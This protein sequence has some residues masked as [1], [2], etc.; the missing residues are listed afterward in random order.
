MGLNTQY[1]K[2]LHSQFG[3]L[4]TWLPTASLKLGDI[5]TI[6]DGVFERTGNLKDLGIEFTAETYP[7]A[8]DLEYASADAVSQEIK[9]GGNVPGTAGSGG[10]VEATVGISFKRANAVLLQASRCNSSV[11]SNIAEIADSILS[12]YAD[13]E[14]PADQVLITDLISADT[15]TVVISSGANAE[16]DLSVK[17]DVGSGVAKL[18]SANASYSVNKASSIGTRIIGQKGATPLFKARGIKRS[19]FPWG[20][21]KFKGS[22]RN[23]VGELGHEGARKLCIS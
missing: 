8:S 12:R 22:S 6:K 21:P 19:L 5:G 23:R 9:G 2:E 11:I 10:M 14:W 3:Y 4:A 13:G 15:L 20:E 7:D 16:I 18:A 17:G 1:A